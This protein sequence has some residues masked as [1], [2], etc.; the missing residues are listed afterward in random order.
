MSLCGL[1]QSIVVAVVLYLCLLGENTLCMY[2]TCL[3]LFAKQTVIC[4][5]ICILLVGV[6]IGLDLL[7]GCCTNVSC[8]HI[9]M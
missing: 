7:S 8:T 2:E 6:L 5:C 3:L 9:H 1:S 4:T